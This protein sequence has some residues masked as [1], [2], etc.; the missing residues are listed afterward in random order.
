MRISKRIKISSVKCLQAK[1]V[2][3]RTKMYTV[4]SDLNSV[5]FGYLTERIISFDSTASS[6]R[7][8]LLAL[9]VGSSFNLR[10]ATVFHHAH[11]NGEA[12]KHRT[13]P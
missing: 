3:T 9:A 8:K 4:N 2:E 5:Q 1:N 7:S 12:S 6:V 10:G 11:L 13:N